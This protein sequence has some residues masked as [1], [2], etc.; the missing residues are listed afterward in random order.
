MRY[1]LRTLLILL[2]V[3]LPAMARGWSEYGKYR[4]RERLREE[5]K[6]EAEEFEKLRR[7]PHLQNFQ[8]DVF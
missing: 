8:L 3:G 5:W 7:S 1:R 4:E 6:R 2:A